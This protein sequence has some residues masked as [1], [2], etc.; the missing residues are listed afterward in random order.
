[1]SEKVPPQ[2]LFSEAPTPSHSSEVPEKISPQGQSR[3]DE[4]RR[5]RIFAEDTSPT[6]RPRGVPISPPVLATRKPK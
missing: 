3:I 6:G 1:M 5:R 2:Q 4:D